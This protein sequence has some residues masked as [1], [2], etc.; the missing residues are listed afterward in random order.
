MM[1]IKKVLIALMLFV[2]C[3]NIFAQQLQEGE[4]RWSATRRLVESDFMIKVSSIK[5]TPIYSQFII[6][7]QIGGFD[8]LKKNLNQKIENVFFQNASWIENTGGYN[9]SELIAYQQVQFDIAEI[10]TRKFRKK[11]IENKK[12]ISKGVDFVN[13]ASQEMMIEFSNRRLL[14]EKET[15]SGNNKKMLKQWEEK[16]ASELLALEEFSFENKDKIKIVK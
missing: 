13:K 15:E 9:T 7:H 5:N 12:E 14:F 1:T 4:L 8:F 10:M 16:V 2:F 11:V 6:R 3:N